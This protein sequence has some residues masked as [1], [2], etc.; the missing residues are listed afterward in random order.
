MTPSRT[1]SSCS[2]TPTAPASRWRSACPA[3]GP[4]DE[5]RLEGQLEPIEV[6]AFDEA[7]F[8]KHPS[9][10]KG[11]IGPGALGEKNESGIRYL[12]DPR[13]VEGTRWVTG[14]D[15]SGSHV[16]D[17]VA[18]RDFTPDGTIEAAEVR[19]GDPVPATVRRHA[20]HRPRHRDGPH[21]RARPQVRRRAR[22]A[23]ARRERQARHRDDG[24]LRHRRL[25]RGRRHRREHPRR[26]RAGLAARGRPRRRAPG[27][28]RQGPRGL[29]GRRHA[30]RRAHRAGPDR[31]L[32]RPPEGLARA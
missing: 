11:Y 12:V 27:R 20:A 5:K 16:L 1:S 32:R 6:E 22:P 21:L 26:R 19:D 7:D 14:A 3:T 15:V 13:V 9:L 18:G 29:R 31:A 10:A 24:L 17:L 8:A 2:S 28:H 30:G 23:G 25:P 4:V